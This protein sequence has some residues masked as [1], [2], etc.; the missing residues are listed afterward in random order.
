MPVPRLCA[1]ARCFY[2]GV[3]RHVR[4]STTGRHVEIHVSL[5]RLV[6]QHPASREMCVLSVDSSDSLQPQAFPGSQDH[7]VAQAGRH[8]QI[9]LQDMAL[10][11]DALRKE[12]FPHHVD[13]VVRLNNGSFGACPSCVMD[14]AEKYRQM[15]MERPDEFWDETLG[16]SMEESRKATA[17]Q[18]GA[19]HCSALSVTCYQRCQRIN[20]APVVLVHRSHAALSRTSCSWTT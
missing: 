14:A 3:R 19:M 16:V 1:A 12:H 9:D 8:R 18:V 11:G 7:Q 17:E 20:S 10:F 6:H 15:W 2:R 4:R 13:T 5:V